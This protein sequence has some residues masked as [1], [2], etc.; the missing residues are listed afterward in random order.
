[1]EMNG[2]LTKN[3]TIKG[4]FKSSGN[5][6]VKFSNITIKPYQGEYVFTPT[7]KMQIV[8]TN[9]FTMME[10]I[11]IKPIPN[12]YGLITWNGQTLTVS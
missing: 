4:N 11:I 9:G 6:S 1:M 3:K 10:D 12:N 7:R 2:I 8:P 5:M